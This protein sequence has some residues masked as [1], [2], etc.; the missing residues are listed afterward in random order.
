MKWA[1][2]RGRG[3]LSHLDAFE[4]GCP[5]SW[6]KCG[7]ISIT[8]QNRGGKNVY[9]FQ[10][11]LSANGRSV[12][13]SSWS[14]SVEPEKKGFFISNYRHHTPFSTPHPPTSEVVFM[15]MGCEPAS[16]RDLS[17]C[18][19]HFQLLSR[20]SPKRSDKALSVICA[21]SQPVKRDWGDNLTQAMKIRLLLLENYG[22]YLPSDKSIWFSLSRV[23]L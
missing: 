2:R 4:M 23:T 1:C 22:I 10:A 5:V 19:A 8:S 17:R 20:C 7:K 18:T 3:A 11:G 13:R 6:R 12:K 21:S 16:E 9:M 15:E 14:F